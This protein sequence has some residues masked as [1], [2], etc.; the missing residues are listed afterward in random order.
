MR[1][2]A[3]FLAGGYQVEHPEAAPH[4]GPRRRAQH[5][6][7]VGRPRRGLA[8]ARPVDAPGAVHA[9]VRVEGAPV[10]ETGEE[11]LAVRGAR[12]HRGP[13]EDGAGRGRPAQVRD[14]ERDAGQRR[15]EPV[16]GETHDV[17]LG[18]VLLLVRRCHGW[19][20]A[21]AASVPPTP[22]FP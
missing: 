3:P 10:V 6:P 22:D 21:S 4:A 9:Q 20:Q 14:H 11:V 15:T 13:L 2:E 7:H 1:E 19:T 17:S 5:R 16:G 8:A 12:R 18:H